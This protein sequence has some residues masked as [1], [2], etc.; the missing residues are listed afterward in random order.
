MDGFIQK[1]RYH[2]EFDSCYNVRVMFSTDKQ[3]KEKRILSL[4]KHRAK[5][6]IPTGSLFFEKQNGFFTNLTC[7]N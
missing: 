6:S 2:P 7:T 3:S 1:Q 4:G 5:E